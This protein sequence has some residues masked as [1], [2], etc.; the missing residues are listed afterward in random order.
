MDPTP[1]FSPDDLV[2][3]E[4]GERQVPQDEMPGSHKMPPW[5]VGELVDAPKFGWRQWT[6]LCVLQRKPTEQM[7]A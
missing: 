1:Q 2:E 3:L 6:M 7:L 5:N 4:S